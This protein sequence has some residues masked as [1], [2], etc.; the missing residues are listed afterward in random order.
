MMTM[1]RVSA[2]SRLALPMMIAMLQLLLL[3]SPSAV[4]VKPGSCPTLPPDTVGTCDEA[5]TVDESCPGEQ[6]CCSNGCGHSCVQPEDLI[7]KDA[8]LVP[9]KPGSCPTLPPDTV[10]TCDEACTDDDSCPGEQKCCSN[11]CGHSC[12]DP[13]VLRPSGLTLPVL[14]PIQ[15]E[16]VAVKPGSCPTPPPDAVGTCDE[17]CTVDESCPGEQKCCSNGCGHSC[18]QPE[19]LI[20]KDAELVAVKPGSCPTLPPDTMG[21]CDEACTDDDSCP[22]EQKCCSNGCGHSC[23]D[24]QVLGPSGLTLPVLKP[25]Q[26]EPGRVKPEVR[27]GCCREPDPFHIQYCIWKNDRCRGDGECPGV[28][29]CCP[30]SCGNRCEDVKP[31]KPKP[32]ECPFVYTSLIRCAF[33]PPQCSEDWQCPGEQ[34][35]CNT[36]CVTACRK[37][38]KNK[39]GF[40]PYIDTIRRIK[41]VVRPDLNQCQQDWQ[42]PDNEKCCNTGCELICIKPVKAG[43]C[44]VWNFSAIVCIRYNDGCRSDD[45][46]PGKQKCCSVPCGVGCVAPD[47]A[48]RGLDNLTDGAS[49]QSPASDR[50]DREGGGV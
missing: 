16:P 36:G 22:G 31:G 7:L 32:G 20:L 48:Q 18:V 11:G 15:V 34:K 14:K 13:Q 30:H 19:D 4:A 25:I 44:P 3:Q 49:P 21:T 50:P 35:C 39:N 37:P 6:K 43:S 8:E 2:S 41:C 27:P 24:P 46:C 42:C 1:V 9:V 28:Q 5:C 10:G 45:D 47:L 17:A 23:V 38:V 12:V 26:V 33:R 29:K 40:C